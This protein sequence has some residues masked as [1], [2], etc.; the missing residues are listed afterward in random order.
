MDDIWALV[1]RHQAGIEAVV[2]GKSLY[3]G[4]LDLAEALAYSREQS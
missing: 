3:S 2:L 4:T 1:A